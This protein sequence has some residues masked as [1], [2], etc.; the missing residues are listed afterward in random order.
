MVL[1]GFIMKIAI[2]GVVY[3]IIFVALRIMYKD[4]KNGGKKKVKK[5]PFGLEIIKPGKNS[6]LKSG[7]VIPIQNNITIGRKEDNMVVLNDE[8]VSGHHARIYI[9]NTDYFL[10]DMN[11]TNGTR[12]NSNKLVGKSIIK[13]GDTISIGT[14]EFKVIG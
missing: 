8:Y 13:K 7:G 2:I 10:E 12:L 14:S 1:L 5:E 4:I 3:I 9:K 6:N 11:S